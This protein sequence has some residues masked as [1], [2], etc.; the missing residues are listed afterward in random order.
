MME[1]KR[2]ILYGIG[3]GPGDPDLITLKAVKALNQVQVV[4]AA[5]SSNNQHSLAVRVAK[6][7]LRPEAGLRLLS[8][9]MT[10][11]HEVTL[12]AWRKNAREIKN[13]LDLGHDCAF[14]TL[15]DPLTYSTFGYVLKQMRD[16]DPEAQIQTIPGICSYQAAAA[17]LNS[18]LVEDEESLVITSGALGGE[19]LRGIS[20]CVENVVLFKAYRNTRDINDAMEETGFLQNSVAVSKCGREDEE[21]IPDVRSLEQRKPNYWTLVLAKKNGKGHFSI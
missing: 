5:A 15:G 17:R 18:I 20:R 6:A 14:L 19:K 2:G 11:D 7:H 12:P 8:F 13:E 9:P 10:K 21:I 16:I 3:V 1:N 4:F